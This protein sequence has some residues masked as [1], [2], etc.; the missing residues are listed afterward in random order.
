MYKIYINETP[1]FLVNTKEV[2][3]NFLPSETCLIA[4]YQGK[5]KSLL[6][7]VDML[8]KSKRFEKVVLHSATP[9]NMWADFKS[10]FKIMKAAGGLVFNTKE[11]ALLIFRLGYWDLPK[12]KIESGEGKKE[13]AIREVQ[14]E[15]GLKEVVLGQKLIRTFHTY[16]DRRNRRALK[17]THWYQMSTPEMDLTPQGEEDILEAIWLDLDTFKLENRKTYGNILDVIQAFEEKNKYE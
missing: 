4:R 15:T 1:L 13:A 2:A 5:T 3:N 14:E 12:G 8:E 17:F 6:H 16:K 11:E 7:Y 9:K 10:Q